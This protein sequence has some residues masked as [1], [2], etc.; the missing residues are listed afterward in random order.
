MRNAL[1]LLSRFAPEE[2][3]NIMDVAMWS[4]VSAVL[5][6]SDLNDQ[7]LFHSTID[8]PPRV[9]RVSKNPDY[10]I[11]VH[12]GEF[13]QTWKRLSKKLC[14]LKVLQILFNLGWILAL[15]LIK[16]VFNLVFQIYLNFSWVLVHQLTF[17]DFS[18]V[19][20]IFWHPWHTWGRVNSGKK[21][22]L[23]I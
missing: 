13:S 20:R 9:P 15:K 14:F 4:D 19:V 17:M 2:W 1:Q 6:H 8:A 10:Q 12:S 22:I 16:R 3:C 18:L 21:W 23:V 5:H 7:N 11:E